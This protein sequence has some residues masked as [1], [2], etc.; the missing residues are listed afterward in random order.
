MVSSIDSTTAT[1]YTMP[2]N[3]SHYFRWNSSCKLQ[4]YD[5]NSHP[6]VHGLSMFY[7]QSKTKKIY[8]YLQTPAI[9]SRVSTPSEL[10]FTNIA[11]VNILTSFSQMQYFNKKQFLK[12]DYTDM[13]GCEWLIKIW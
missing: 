12:K 1:A 6:F 3:E 13:D 10:C 2:E 7:I 5:Q 9:L 11:I 8:Y 4:W